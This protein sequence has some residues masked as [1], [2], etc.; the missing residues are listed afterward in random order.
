MTATTVDGRKVITTEAALSPMKTKTGKD[1][2]FSRIL[3]LLLDDGTTV[4]GCREC[5]FTEPR[6]ASVRAHL[7]SH[8][9][10][11][12]PEAKPVPEPRS[13]RATPDLNGLTHLTIAELLAMGQR[14]AGTAEALD[15][16]TDDRNKWKS[17]ATALKRDLTTIR[18]ALGVQP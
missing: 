14:S 7:R 12:Q 15:R 9:P 6:L 11:T 8:G 10:Q 3:R 2:A 1:I 17:E 16:M 4:H 5:D 18:R 13:R